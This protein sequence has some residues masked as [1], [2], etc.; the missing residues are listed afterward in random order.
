MRGLG[1][2]SKKL[3]RLNGPERTK[4]VRNQRT[5]CFDS[6]V[7]RPR[8]SSASFRGKDSSSRMRIGCKNFPRQLQR[9]NRLCTSY[10]GKLIEKDF[11]AVASLKV[12][13]QDF[14]GN[15]GP[16]KYRRST[17]DLRISVHDEI[18]IGQ[19]HILIS[20]SGHDTLAVAR[21]ITLGLAGSYVLR[22]ERR[23]VF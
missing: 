3:A 8:S 22:R 23:R 18:W 9:C 2:D 13:E 6:V 19:C 15:P 14:D 20:T 10:R 12:V 21:R 11:K 17:Q 4:H 5:Q 16:C 1:T 7:Y